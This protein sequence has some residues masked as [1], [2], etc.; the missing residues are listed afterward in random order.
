MGYLKQE[1]NMMKEVAFLYIFE[2]HLPT[3]KLFYGKW[4]SHVIKSYMS[5]GITISLK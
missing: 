2:D 1:E 5:F 4:Q 3:S